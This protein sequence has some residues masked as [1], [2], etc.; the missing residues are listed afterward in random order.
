MTDRT[1]WMGA[2][3]VLGMLAGF[4]AGLWWVAQ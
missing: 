1:D 4:V 3:C 2:L